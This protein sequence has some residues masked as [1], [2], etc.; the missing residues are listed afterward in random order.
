M[1]LKNFN[2]H[3]DVYNGPSTIDNRPPKST[4]LNPKGDFISI[5]LEYLSINLAFE[6]G[7]K[8]S[9]PKTKSTKESDAMFF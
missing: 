8:F 5:T 4:A 9:L 2:V 7:Q 3:K 1:P 6:S